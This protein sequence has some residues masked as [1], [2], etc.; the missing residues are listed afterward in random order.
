MVPNVWSAAE[1]KSKSSK[2]FSSRSLQLQA[3]DKAL[4]HLHMTSG[5]GDQGATAMMDLLEAIAAWRKHKMSQGKTSGRAR[6]V[7]T[8]QQQLATA[9]EAIYKRKVGEQNTIDLKMHTQKT[10]IQNDMKSM[11]MMGGK[12]QMPVFPKPSIPSLP[13]KPLSTSPIPQRS[14]TQDRL[15]DVL[16]QAMIDRRRQVMAYDDEDLFDDLDVK[17]QGR[18]A[19]RWTLSVPSGVTDINAARGEALRIIG[20]MLGNDI[21]MVK[22]LLANNIEVVVIPRDQGMTVLDQFQSIRGQL[23]F[24]GRSWDPVRGVGNVKDPS[25]G[26]QLREHK[27]LKEVRDSNKGPGAVVAIDPAK[28]KIY[29]AITEENLLGGLT[30]APGGGCYATGYSTTTHEFAHSIYAYGLSSADRA[31]IDRIYKN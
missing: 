6:A 11:G 18:L 29:T 13:Q 31:T 12:V 21:S 30:T 16:A 2:I 19:A 10:N 7:D 17:Q 1:F 20:A 27:M 4:A 24:D 9:A 5:V 28:G 22:T 15:F 25:L 8:L 14:P 23:T 3:I 26:G